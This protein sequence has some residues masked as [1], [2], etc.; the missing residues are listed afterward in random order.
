MQ[1][2]LKNIRSLCGMSQEEFAK[3]I[4]S[5]F[6]SVNR[7][8]NGHHVPNRMAQS[9]I[10]ELCQ[11]KGVP[12]SDIV[13]DHV[14]DRVKA[15]PVAADCVLLFHGSK[16][17]IQ[18]KITPT[19]RKYCDFGAGFYMGTEVLQAL[20]LI[21]GYDD[22]RFYVVTIPSTGL[23]TLEI[24]ADLDWAF[25]VAFYR[26]K[27]ESINGS[28]LYNRYAK[29]VTGYDYIIGSI[30]ND[31]MFY[32]LDNFFLGNITDVALLQSLSALQLGKQYVAVTQRACDHVRIEKEIPLS[33]LEKECLK[34]LSQQN[35]VHGINLANEICKKHRREGRYF[36]EILEDA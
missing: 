36:D 13:L 1:V 26:G 32:V 10:L 34:L 17:G 11:D 3:T 24:P 5:T 22:S 35:R 31:R 27:L 9:R 19:S 21:C 20:T 18:G 12:L 30:A 33:F 7:W 16:S 8:E 23:H 25:L 15:I 29:M 2:L 14:M 28:K 6:A 4:G